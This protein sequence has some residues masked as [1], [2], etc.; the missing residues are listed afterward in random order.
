MEITIKFGDN[1]KK[2]DGEKLK[3][4]VK[5]VFW[6]GTWRVFNN[7]LNAMCRPGRNIGY[8]MNAVLSGELAA[9]A[10]HFVFKAK[11]TQESEE[12]EEPTVILCKAE[13]EPK[14]EGDAKSWKEVVI[15]KGDS[16]FE[17]C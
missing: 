6:Y 17:D 2:F 10:T 16:D 3:K 14:E 8:L 7:S 11:D 4:Y 9:I 5:P 12:K 13:E 15:E 1:E